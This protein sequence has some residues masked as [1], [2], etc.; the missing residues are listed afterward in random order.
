MRLS[1]PT[2]HDVGK[3]VVKRRNIRGVYFFRDVAGN[4][5]NRGIQNP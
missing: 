4:E 1:M 5:F 3:N 2:K